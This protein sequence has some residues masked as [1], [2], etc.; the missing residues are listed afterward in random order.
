MSP[1]DPRRLVPARLDALPA[2]VAR[3]AYDRAAVRIGV[4]HLGPGAFHRAHQAEAFDRLLAHDPHWGIC[5][6]SLKSPGV[7]DALAPQDGLYT[8][9]ELDE[10][11][12][13]RVIGAIKQVLAAPEDPEA[14]F[15]QMAS[16]EVAVISLTVTEKGYALDGHGA[17]DVDHPDVRRDLARPA[18]PASTV[19]WLAEGLR[20]RRAAGQ[21]GLS[22]I[23]CDNLTDNGRK[24]GAAVRA[25]ACAQGDEALAAWIEAEVAFPNTMVD[26]ITPATTE[27]LRQ[28]VRERLGLEDAWPIQREAFT[29]WVV[30]DALAPAAPD[31][32]A[33]GVTLTADVRPFEEAKLR[34]LNGSHSALAYLGSLLNLATTAD[35]V[36][37]PALAAFVER[38]MRQDMIPSLTPSPQ[39]DLGAYVDSLLHRFRNPQIG[40]KLSQIAWDGSQKLPFRL[41]GPIRQAQAAGRPIE[42][43]CVP[44]AAWIAFVVR[45]AQ[46]GAPITDPLAPTLEALG[47]EAGDDFAAMVE[48]FL[49]LAAMFPADL[50]ANADFRHAVTA[51]YARLARGDVRGVLAL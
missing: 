5:A 44:L 25:L 23:S 3:P 11:I 35:A 19:G 36:G 49:G 26:S 24:L 9:V 17:L 30:E 38:L 33:V 39:L 15:A 37:E 48:A 47:R 2:D 7:R 16:P 42:R 18:T 8:L 12:R 27:A 10:T 31:L 29:Q 40:H 32:A 4:V 20:R 50:A 46:A 21:G 13:Y 14:V 1:T 6:V 45:Q 28:R 22:V 34:L 51:S 43:L 41:F